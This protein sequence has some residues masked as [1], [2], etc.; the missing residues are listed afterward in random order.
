M[1]SF[2]QRAGEELY[3]PYMP[4][5]FAGKDPAWLQDIQK[6]PRGVNFYEMEKKF[7]DWLKA[8]PDAKKKTVDK[9]PAV[10][11]YRRWRKAYAP[12]V[13]AKGNIVLP[14]KKEYLAKIDQQNRAN[15]PK[16][17][18]RRSRRSTPSASPT[19]VWKNI[20]PDRT[21]RNNGND[22]YLPS[23]DSHANVFRI[24]VYKKNP[25]I[26]YCGAETGVVFKT[27][28]GGE[29][30]TACDPV[31][32]FGKEI[33]ALT[34]N[35]ENDDE[36]WVG[37]DLGLFVTEDGGNT[38]ERI[39]GIETRINSIKVNSNNPNVITIAGADGFY[40]YN[41]AM[42][43]VQKTFHAECFDHELKPKDNSTVYLLGKNVREYTY[44][45]YISHDNGYT[46]SESHR[47]LPNVK[48][49][50]LAVSQAP[51]GEDYLYALV[52]VFDYSAHY[53]APHIVQSKDAGRSWK[54][55]TTR[56]EP[57]GA[58]DNTFCPS[59]D[60]KNGG[61]GF[62]DMMIGVSDINPEHVIFG[63]CSAYRSKK[64]GEGG[65]WSNSIGGYCSGNL[66]MHPDMQDVAIAGDKVW[67]ANDGG[68]KYSPD[69]FTDFKKVENRVTGIYA[70]DF[71]GF[72]Q[73]WNEDVMAGG[74][75]HNGDAVMI[76]NESY[77]YGRISVNVGGVEQATG[78]V[79]LSN[80]KKVYFTDAGMFTMPD[81]I[82]GKVNFKSNSVFSARPQESLQ[83]NGFLGFDPRY[84]KRMLYHSKSSNIWVP[85]PSYKIIETTNDGEE[86]SFRELL[87]TYDGDDVK[88]SMHENFSNV[89]FARSNPNTIYAAGNRHIYK[90]KDNGENWEML[91]P[92]PGD[93]GFQYGHT[94]TPTSF[95]DVD[96]HDE[97]KIW[98]V[99]QVQ[100]GLYFIVITEVSLG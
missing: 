40:V 93:L 95:I 62:Y 47:I 6:N 96:P 42:S 16:A 19:N 100:K 61:Q 12:F 72:G 54:D 17:S 11:F 37:S 83:S 74:R 63:L 97:N 73:G 34:I 59:I 27:T 99:H 89:V 36:V 53:G 5:Y 81:D 38:F 58:R 52:N 85:E 68:V 30:W 8:D 9:K 66:Q 56:K 45:L 48:F 18:S 24:D 87:N 98:V 92:I 31:Y 4:E 23:Y 88:E 55:M 79:M 65:Y 76:N 13:D 33:S 82:K 71:W 64:G 80:P 35:Q 75:W 57:L 7:Q 2:A 1:S 29:K 43:R 69:F 20:G 94:G 78:Y 26:L 39:S 32:N 49:G 10:N 28:N 21:A 3:D 90:S 84:A 67:I 60:A 25:Q 86:G 77:G 44:D 51:G 22:K 46:F 50:R 41:R 15:A 70:S 91:D 14:N